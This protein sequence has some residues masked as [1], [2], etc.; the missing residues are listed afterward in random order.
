MAGILHVPR[1]HGQGANRVRNQFLHRRVIARTGS[2]KC[3]VL[4]NERQEEIR[5][6]PCLSS[7]GPII[8]T[9][10]LG[11]TNAQDFVP[12]CADESSASVAR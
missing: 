4:E 1:V 2:G 6:C 9:E 12:S 7:R 11:P 5:L 8:A 10:R 3:A